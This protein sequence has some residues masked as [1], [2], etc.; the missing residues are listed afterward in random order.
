M[1]RSKE[2]KKQIHERRRRYIHCR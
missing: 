2:K 1:H